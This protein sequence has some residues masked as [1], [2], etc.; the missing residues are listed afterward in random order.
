MTSF[1]SSVVESEDGITVIVRV[2]VTCVVRAE[3]V[4][5][6]VKLEDACHKN[7]VVEVVTEA[8]R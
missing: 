1:S 2:S 7:G 6:T 3:R 8:G 4:G 5:I